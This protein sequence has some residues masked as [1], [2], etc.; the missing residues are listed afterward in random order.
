MITHPYICVPTSALW[1]FQPVVAEWD[2]ERF[3]KQSPATAYLTQSIQTLP[4][5]PWWES[6]EIQSLIGG[7]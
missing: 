3:R 6:G 2:L 4:P 7:G 1:D 5:E